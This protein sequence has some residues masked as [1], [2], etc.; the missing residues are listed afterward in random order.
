MGVMG[1]GVGVLKHFLLGIGRE[2]ETERAEMGMT[3]EEV[4]A[5]MGAARRGTKL[6]AGREC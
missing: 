5:E 4:G 6:A 1:M 3:R 2:T